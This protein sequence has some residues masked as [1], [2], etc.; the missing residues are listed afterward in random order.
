M[1]IRQFTKDRISPSGPVAHVKGIMTIAA[2]AVALTAIATQTGTFPDAN[3]GDIVSLS[4]KANLDGGLGIAW[5]RVVDRDV[6]G[7][8]VAT[9]VVAFSNIGA[10]TNTGAITFDVDVS[11]Q[12]GQS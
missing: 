9:I 4:P 1:T 12:H 5:A 7:P 6:Q 11:V 2:T 10:S 3:V 8:G